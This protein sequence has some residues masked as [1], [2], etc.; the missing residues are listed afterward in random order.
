ML[1]HRLAYIL[2]IGPVPAGLTLDH[3]CRHRAC[4]NPAHLEAITNHENILRGAGASAQHARQ[5]HCV[6]GHP[7][8]AVNT[9]I[10]KTVGRPGRECKECSRLRN[11]ERY[12]AD[13]KR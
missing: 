3:L 13:R 8:D 10:R 5:T 2:E 12:R 9:Y 6:N 4:V 11:R 1:A 7:F